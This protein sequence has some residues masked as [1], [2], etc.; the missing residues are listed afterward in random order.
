M[1]DWYEIVVS[2][3]EEALAAFV[4]AAEPPGG[5]SGAAILAR[6]LGIEG[7]RLAA[8]LRDVF[9]RGQRH[10]VFAPADAARALVAGLRAT[11][12]GSGLEVRELRAIVRARL[13]FSA[14]AFSPDAAARARE[15]LLRAQPPGVRCA[16]TDEHEESDP[17]ARGPELY[18]PEHAY[19]YRVS[20]VFEG[21]FP[22]VVEM[23]RRV[24]ELPF[25]EAGPLER[26]THPADPPAPAAR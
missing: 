8:M 20:G 2:G 4:A 5:R 13:R 22:G 18:T 23:R 26:E 12:R 17:S 11:G 25:A 10:L 19:A 16:E 1:T 9:A 7:G 21:P 3:P 15:A 6:D 14:A 24:L